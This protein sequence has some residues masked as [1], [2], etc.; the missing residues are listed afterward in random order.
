M[1]LMSKSCRV[2]IPVDLRKPKVKVR[3]IFMKAKVK[4]GPDWM[5]DDEVVTS[6]FF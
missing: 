5:Y 6:L 1:L 4:R 2:H 3:G